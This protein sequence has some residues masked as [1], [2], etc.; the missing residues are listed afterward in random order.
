MEEPTGRFVVAVA[1]REASPLTGGRMRKYL[2]L[3]VTA[4]VACMAMGSVASADDIQSIDANFKPTKLDK[5]KYK[6]VTLFVDVKTQNN[7][8]AAVNAD[9][10]PTATRT[11]VSFSKDLKFD[12]KAVPNCKVDSNTITNT[13]ADQARQACG[14]GSQV[15]VDSGTHGEVT[16]DT[17]PAVANGAN[18]KLQIQITAFN[19]KENNTIYLHT[20]PQGIPTKPVLVGKLVKGSGAYGSVL[21]VTIPPLGAG[22]ISDFTTTVKGGKYVQA[23]C[24][25]KTAQYLA[26]T[27][28]SDWTGGSKAV[29]DTT[30]T[31]KQKKSKKKKHKK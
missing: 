22:G 23:R 24:K 10:P 13:T 26:T 17:N 11:D 18:T 1:T 20:D 15:S 29:D 30:S 3:A 5:K 4:L 2:I 8:G 28:F 31:C 25:A 27:T 19:G 9:Q 21:Q 12:P 7:T 16:I 14:A 6:P